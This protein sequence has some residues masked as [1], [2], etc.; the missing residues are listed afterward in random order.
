MPSET[1][2]VVAVVVGVADVGVE[3]TEVETED[4]PT[5]LQHLRRPAVQDIKDPSILIFQPVIGQDVPCIL[6]TGR[7]HFSVQNLQH[8]LGRTS[9]LQDQTNEGLTSLVNH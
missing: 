7:E 1:I 4:R 8:V 5:T 3:E 9:T 6:N 2:E